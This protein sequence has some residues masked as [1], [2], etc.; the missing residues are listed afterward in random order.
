MT[1]NGTMTNLVV[2]VQ[3]NC[4]SYMLL[5][6]T[7]KQIYK[8]NALKRSFYM[9]ACERCARKINTCYKDDIKI[10]H[11]QRSKSPKSKMASGNTCCSQ[12]TDLNRKFAPGL[13]LQ[14]FS[15]QWNSR[16]SRQG[17]MKHCVVTV[18]Q[19][20]VSQSTISQSTNSQSTVSQ[21]TIS[22]RFVS[23]RKVL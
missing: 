9:C 15:F 4:N 14:I 8:K 3:F 19:S 23:F 22:F 16:Y 7:K 12:E 6:V 20:T 21:S 1:T 2:I 11:T 13:S 10:V 17:V 5:I 18:S